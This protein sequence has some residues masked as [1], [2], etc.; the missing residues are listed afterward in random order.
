[1]H[2][3]YELANEPAAGNSNNSLH[4]DCRVS[5]RRHRHELTIR[6]YRY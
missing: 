1:M 4:F 3:R 5:F 2:H 6:E